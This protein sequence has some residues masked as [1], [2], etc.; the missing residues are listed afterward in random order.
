M[1]SDWR[2]ELK[3]LYL[4]SSKEVS[5][6]DVPKMKFLMLDGEGAPGSADMGKTFEALYTMAF[7]VKFAVKKKDPKKDFKVYPA[8]GLWWT[9]QDGSI[10]P[11]KKDKWKWT[12]M[13]GQPDQV[14]SSIVEEVRGQAMKKKDNPL[15]AMVRFEEFKEGKAAQIMHI[16]RY[17]QET[18]NIE[19]IV[20]HIHSLGKKVSGKHHEIYLS[21][22]SRV[23]PEK[24]KT[25]VRLPF[26]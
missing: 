6:V 24:M 23:P 3:E 21:D 20:K 10:D 16:G 22:P 7:G 12:I 25:V 18:Q 9:N 1:A 15:L 8:E 2:K 11:G 19:K 13:V 4:P 5:V 14:T 26:K 17:D